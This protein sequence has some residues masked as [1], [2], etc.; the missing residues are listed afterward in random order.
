MSKP[1]FCFTGLTIVAAMT[2]YIVTPF[3]V[4]A[5]TIFE[6]Y[7]ETMSGPEPFK[8]HAEHPALE[9]VN[10][11]DMRFSGETIELIP[12]YKDLLRLCT[13]LNLLSA[14]QAGR[15]ARNV[16]EKT[17]QRVLAS[18]VELREALAA[19]L[20]S[21]ID[22]SKVPAAEV[23]KLERHFQSAAVHR[24]LLAGASHWYWSWSG[25]ERKAE[26]P[27]WILAQ[28]ATDL[29]VSSDAELIKDCGDP[30]CRWLF[31]DISKNHTRRWCDMK[32]CG[33]RMKARRHQAR[34]QGVS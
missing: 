28:A 18:T 33:N 9:L 3:S 27:L 21:R 14:Q 11:L 34:Y 26:I 7:N 10:T 32:T 15:L 5:E 29:L 24:R 17:A 22:G 8:L 1:L 31:L 30:T 20:Y 12:T 2:G 6:G 19:V 23:E 16:D 13:Q 4:T 25:A